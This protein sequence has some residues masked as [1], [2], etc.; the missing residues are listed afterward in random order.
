MLLS[1]EV[2]RNLSLELSNR[3]LKMEVVRME[4][5]IFLLH[6]TSI[7]QLSGKIRARNLPAIFI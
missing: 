2:E 6:F 7:P 1:T 3:S 5:V 4:E